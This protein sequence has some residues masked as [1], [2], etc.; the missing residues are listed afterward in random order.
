[1]KQ[2]CY[3]PKVSNYHNYGRRGI[4]VC[5]EWLDDFQAFYDWAISHGYESGL[6]IDRI[7]ND[8]DYSPSNCQW[9]TRTEQSNNTRTNKH[10]TYNG[11]TQTINQWARE[12]N[13]GDGTLRTR[14]NLGW[15]V[16]KTLTTPVRNHKEYKVRK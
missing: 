4:A 2:R 1:M 10:L 12:L 14:L 13:I 5:D 16:E 8:G 11:K 7:D 6:S 3:N 15:D 9:A